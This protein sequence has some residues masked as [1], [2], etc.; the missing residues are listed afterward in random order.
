MEI[1]KHA[2]SG[3]RWLFLLII[4]YAIINAFRK[5]KAGE[6]FGA[7]DKLISILAIAL[8]HSQAIIGF[9]LLF[10]SPKISFAEGFMKNDVIRF[11]LTQH[12]FGMIL[13]V[14]FITIGHSKAKRAKKDSAKFRK[15]FI[16]FS[17]ALLLV[18]IS[19]PWPFF[20]AGAG[21]F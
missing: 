2:H 13:A 10:I 17:I 12:A 20:V 6:K 4:I 5:W 7:K 15:I 1:L 19:I 9:V 16:W 18:L 3:L 21:L 14:V 11:Y 8:T